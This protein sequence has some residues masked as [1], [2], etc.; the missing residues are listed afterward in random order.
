M[1][2]HVYLF[3]ILAIVC[4][5]E[6]WTRAGVEV[7]PDSSLRSISWTDREERE[8]L[9]D[10]EH[11][12]AFRDVILEET[13]RQFF[14]VLLESSKLE[15]KFSRLPI[16]MNIPDPV[17]F[18]TNIQFKKSQ[19]G[20]YNINFNAGDM[21]ISGLHNL[22]LKTLHILRHMGLRDIRAVMQLSTDL[23]LDGFYNL[24]GTGLSMIPI[25]GNGALQ[26]KANN[27]I[28][29]GETYLLFREEQDKMYIRNIDI[30]VMNDKLDVEL[31]NLMGNGL[32]SDVAN[33]ILDVIGDD[34]FYSHK[35]FLIS[36]V[37]RYFRLGIS[38]MLEM[39]EQ[40]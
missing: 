8:L 26:V 30:K 33:S 11:K 21:K 25:E 13:V 34:M 31:E 35:D 37:K 16:G 18:D 6:T 40:Y 2:H 12:V 23:Q 17:R 22:Q 7:V 10:E 32:V 38:Q 15:R 9:T 14:N 27:L 5:Q 39:E 28:V 24:T 1:V 19:D 4:L 29:T 36:E 3:I 20:L